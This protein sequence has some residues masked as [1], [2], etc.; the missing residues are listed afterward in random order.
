MTSLP[1]TRNELLDAVN[2]D[3]EMDE[4][5]TFMVED[6][7]MPTAIAG[8]RDDSDELR[9]MAYAAGHTQVHVKIEMLKNDID[10]LRKENQELRKMITEVNEEATGCKC[11]IS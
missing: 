6:G 1:A 9:D 7:T 3:D 4:H 8:N 11:I 5:S 2:G 10:E